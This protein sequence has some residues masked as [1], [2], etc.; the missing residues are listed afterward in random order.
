MQIGGIIAIIVAASV[1]AAAVV[2][3]GLGLGLGLGLRKPCGVAQLDQTVSPKVDYMCFDD[4]NSN[5]VPLLLSG[6]GFMKIGQ[7]Q[8]QVTIFTDSTTPYYPPTSIDSQCPYEG[9]CVVKAILGKDML[10]G[11]SM[12]NFTA[13]VDNPQPCYT[14]QDMQLNSF[15]SKLNGQRLTAVYLNVNHL[16][17]QQPLPVSPILTSGFGNTVTI[18]GSGFIATKT[19]GTWNY[20]TVTLTAIGP[21]TQTNVPVYGIDGCTQISSS[22][23]YSCNSMTIRFYGNSLASK[24]DPNSF[25]LDP[26]WYDKDLAISVTNTAIA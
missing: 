15:K 24:N 16:G 8:P 25:T 3:L 13:F 1:S 21:N 2:S 19:A 17:P 20:P 14:V 5:T 6:R 23:V 18:S 12:T 10:R 22:Q 9:Q 11:N 26:T 4:S 7:T